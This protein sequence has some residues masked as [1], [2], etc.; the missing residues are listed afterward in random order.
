MGPLALALLF[1]A[2]LSAAHAVVY[3]REQFMDGVKWQD[4]W[5]N[6]QYKSDYGKFRLTAGKFY[7]NAVRD[8]GPDICG[9]ETK[10]V[11]VI[12]NYKSKPH[13]MKKRIRCKVDGFTHLYTLILRPDQTYEVKIDN[14]IIESGNLEDDW[15]FL[16]PRKINDPTAKKPK[17]WDDVPQIADP[18]DVKPEDWDEPEYILDTTAEKPEDWDNATNGEW[19][20]PL[21]KNPLYRGEWK[22]RKIDNPNY[23][24][25]WP[26]PQ[27]E[28][29]NY[30]PDFNIY[31]YEN[32]S[33]IGLDLWQVRAG[34]IF[35]NFLITDDEQYAEDFGDNTWGETKD[36]EEKMNIKQTEEEKKR[37]RAKEEKRFRTRFNKK[38]EKP[39]ESG[40]DKSNRI[41]LKKEEL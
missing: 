21:I 36:P 6:S 26:C 9:S 38:V 41:T 20:P 40:K 18:N 14:E 2:A 5:M 22:P 19:Q 31:S 28:N 24:G 17:D 27:I 35:D 39:K 13:P 25:V 30:S 10:K 23:K 3:F 33:I 37:E 7:G 16:P 29:P 8:K 4:R 34:T 1:W 15:D 32:I 11:H 12:L